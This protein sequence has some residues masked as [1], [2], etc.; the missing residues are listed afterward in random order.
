[1]TELKQS[2]KRAMIAFVDDAHTFGGAQIAMA[3]AIR[4]ILKHADISVLCVCPL[5]TQQAV[6]EIV[7]NHDR[8]RFVLCPPAL[9]LNIFRFPLRL[10]TFFSILRP[11]VAEGV[12]VWWM[13]LS[14]I[15]FGLAPKSVL[16]ALGQ[17]NV[18][19][20]HNSETFSVFSSGGSWLRRRLST[21]RDKIAD[22]YLFR[23]YPLIVTP[24]IS[25]AN[26]LRERVGNVAFNIDHLYPTMGLIPASI[27]TQQEELSPS[28][29]VDIWM[30]GRVEYGHK[31]N[32][33]ALEVLALLDQ[34]GRQATLTI[35]GGGPDL[36][37]LMRRVHNS[38]LREKVTFIGWSKCPWKDV[39]R[40]A[41][42]F[43]PSI[44]EGHSLVA[45]EALLNGV[46][47]VAS[48]IPSFFEAIPHKLIA[49]AFTAEAFAR[50]IIEVRDTT[51]SDLSLL[52][53]TT[54]AKYPESAFV[55]SILRLSEM[56]LQSGPSKA[57]KA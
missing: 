55:E 7:G 50:R 10:S 34:Q 12:S 21:I 15:E 31:N 1:M 25:S 6:M 53:E 5:P 42:I 19:W 9:S 45:R 3:W 44:F 57:T 22:Q 49:D 40:D 33:A 46:R 23:S 24:S 14:G 2:N 26:R 56:P 43:M 16:A 27:R 35:C 28:T 51:R 11:L 39:P 38:G 54:L 47:L 36:I 8:L 52:Y 32:L 13:N 17:Q 48:P 30:I 37:D 18:A 4:A 20:L 29:K 41:I